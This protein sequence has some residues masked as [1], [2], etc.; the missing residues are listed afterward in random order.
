M[1]RCRRHGRPLWRPVSGEHLSPGDAAD[2]R[3]PR[4]PIHVRNRSKFR[5]GAQEARWL[6]LTL[7][8]GSSFHYDEALNASNSSST[9]SFAFA[10]WFEDN[11]DPTR[12]D[13]NNNTIIY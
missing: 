2:R 10:S 3:W 9:G 8:G 7:S 5:R 13:V 6:S 11:S 12:K 1:A 4:R